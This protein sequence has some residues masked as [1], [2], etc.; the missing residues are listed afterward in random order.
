MP[1]L[2][3][4]TFGAVFGPK[5]KVTWPITSKIWH[6][7]T[8]CYSEAAVQFSCSFYFITLW[9]GKLLNLYENV[10]LTKT[11]FSKLRSKNQQFCAK[12]HRYRYIAINANLFK[13]FAKFFNS[14]FCSIFP[15]S[16]GVVVGSKILNA[17]VCQDPISPLWKS[18]REVANPVLYYTLRGEPSRVAPSL[19]TPV[20]LIRTFIANVATSTTELNNQPG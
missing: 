14:G 19:A 13:K 15:I 20:P 9:K 11:I 12:I 4:Q 2:S 16:S 3:C 1:L 6:K 8:S 17:P 7:Q 5:F 18:F 10:V